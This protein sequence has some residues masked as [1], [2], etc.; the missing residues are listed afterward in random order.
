MTFEYQVKVSPPVSLP[1]ESTS[2]SLLTHT[3]VIS[4]PEGTPFFSIKALNASDAAAAFGLSASTLCNGTYR[5]VPPRALI[6]EVA[7]AATLVSAPSVSS[8]EATSPPASV[9][10]LSDATSVPL[11]ISVNLFVRLVR[12]FW[13]DIFTN[14][15]IAPAILP[16]FNALAVLRTML[17]SFKSESTPGILAV[18]LSN[19]NGSPDATAWITLAPVDT[20]LSSLTVLASKPGSL[21][22]APAALRRNPKVSPLSK[23]LTALYICTNGAIGG[24]AIANTDSRTLPN[25]P[26]SLF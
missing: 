26:L 10:K 7:N 5:G 2:F 25:P 11:A 4:A 16:S 22:D 9:V 6:C 8:V 12:L 17:R 15:L 18:A 1:S 14:P 19:F 21:V 3:G 24:Y 23:A 20:S 13:F